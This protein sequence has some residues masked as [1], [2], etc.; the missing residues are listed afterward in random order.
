MV[1]LHY[2]QNVACNMLDIDS[3]DRDSFRETAKAAS[4]YLNEN[5]WTELFLE[6]KDNLIFELDYLIEE[7]KKY[8]TAMKNDDAKTLKQLLK[9]GREAKEKA[10]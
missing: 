10:D 4:A 8:S 1:L 5:M 3:G 2:S 6:N 9:D 7:L